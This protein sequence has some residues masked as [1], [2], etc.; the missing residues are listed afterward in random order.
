M[1]C[2]CPAHSFVL[3]LDGFE[4]SM[5]LS[6]SIIACAVRK[7]NPLRDAG[8]ISGIDECTAMVYDRESEMIHV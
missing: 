5:R 1:L 6:G 8:W 2:I 7:C 4:Q 3:G